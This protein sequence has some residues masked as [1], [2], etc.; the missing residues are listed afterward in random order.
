MEDENVFS[1]NYSFG[2]NCNFEIF[3]LAGEP[4]FVYYTTSN[5]T[6]SVRDFLNTNDGRVAYKVV[7]GSLEKKNICLI[8]RILISD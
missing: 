3:I 4:H 8:A 7:E 1:R 6:K 5:Y 2:G